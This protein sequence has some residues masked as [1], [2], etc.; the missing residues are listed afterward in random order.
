M[1]PASAWWQHGPVLL[2][3]GTFGGIGSATD[4]I[5]RGMD[6]QTA[7]ATMDEAARLGITL[8][9]TAGGYA[10]GASE[11]MIGRWL[12]SRGDE[13]AGV[14]RL[15]TKALPPHL[16]GSDR[17]FDA[18]YLQE[19]VEGSLERLGVESVELFLTHAPDDATPIEETLE[20]LEA[21]REAGRSRLLGAC[22][23]DASQLTEALDA[24][25]RLGV[26]GYQV[27]QNGYSLLEPA[28]EQDVREI[29]AVRGLAFTAFSPLAGGVLT[30]KY[31]RASA[32]PS[33]TRLDLR[34][35]GFDELL[36]D[37]RF[38]AI[39]RLRERA[40]DR[41]SVDCGAL[42]LSWLTD[43]PSVTAVITGPSRAAPHLGLAQ[44][45]LGLDLS[46]VERSEIAAWFASPGPA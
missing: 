36:T 14:I 9:D 26:A 32:A 38:D 12:V 30:G 44:Q 1:Q 18:A 11:E 7:F 20:G 3:C 13:A 42:A 22:N 27:V 46:E 40:R 34:P 45:A 6:E 25:A 5:G 33:G 23:V 28:D 29:C 19:S 35:E 41:H 10:A 16:H 24:A 2:G 21:L 4:L 39:D 8:F 43:D 31:R 37:E 15:A 17:R